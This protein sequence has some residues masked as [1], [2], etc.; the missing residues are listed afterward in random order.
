MCAT[1]A[2]HALGNRPL[3]AC[4]AHTWPPLF[5]KL[6]THTALAL[7]CVRGAHPRSRS[8]SRVAV[9]EVVVVPAQRPVSAFGQEPREPLVTTT[10]FVLVELEELLDGIAPA[11]PEHV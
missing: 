9:H 8:K 4:L 11:G 7:Q 10:S 2:L 3:D 6:E 1:R 5:P